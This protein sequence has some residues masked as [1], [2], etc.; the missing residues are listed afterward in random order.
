MSEIIDW[1]TEARNTERWREGAEQQAIRVI[2]SLLQGIQSPLDAAKTITDS[3]DTG[4]FWYI[5]CDAARKLGGVLQNSE[6]LVELMNGLHEMSNG[7]DL[8]HG[9][10]FSSWHVVFRE[11]GNCKSEANSFTPPLRKSVS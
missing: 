9:L 2:A 10:N 8:A 11:Y 6:R 3:H 4:M 1:E 7:G 5:L